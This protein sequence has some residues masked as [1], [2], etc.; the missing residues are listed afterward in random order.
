[1]LFGIFS[2]LLSLVGLLAYVLLASAVW[3][4]WRMTWAHEKIEKHVAGIERMMA[5]RVSDENS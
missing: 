4:V 2:V 3:A 5:S 1:M